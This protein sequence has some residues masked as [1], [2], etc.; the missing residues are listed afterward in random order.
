MVSGAGRY[1]PRRRAVP[2]AEQN[3]LGGAAGEVWACGP[4]SVPDGPFPGRPCALRAAWLTPSD[5]P[6]VRLGSVGALYCGEGNHD[7]QRHNHHA[8][9]QRSPPGPRS[10]PDP[11]AGRHRTGS[12]APQ[13]WPAGGSR[14]PVPLWRL[15]HQALLRRNSQA[16]R[17]LRHSPGPPT[18]PPPRRRS[19]ELS[20]QYY[21]VASR[22][23]G[24]RPLDPCPCPPTEERNGEGWKGPDGRG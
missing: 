16:D 20:T 24:L 4:P 21:V 9:A 8:E 14:C 6:Q 15:G 19:P 7:R 3:G 17:V 12:P 11:G 13:G 23:G 2:G 1:P 5:T 10:G 22:V 18:L